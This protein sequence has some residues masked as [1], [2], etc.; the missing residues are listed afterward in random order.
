MQ[1]DKYILTDKYVLFHG[2]FLSNWYPCEIVTKNGMSFKSS[3]QLYMYLKA[4]FFGDF[5]T[6]DKIYKSETPRESKELGRQVQNFDQTKWNEV[7]YGIMY[8][9]VHMKFDQNEDLK[10]ELLRIGEGRKFVEGSP[11]DKI[12]GI[13]IDYRSPEAQDETKWNGKNWLGKC[14]TETYRKISDEELNRKLFK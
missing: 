14:L 8:A 2:S 10:K 7:S 1:K 5:E 12:W 11:V 13:G 3:E 9:V 4:V 6:A